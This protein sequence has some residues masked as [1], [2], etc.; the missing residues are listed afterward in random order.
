MYGCFAP[1]SGPVHPSARNLRTSSVHDVCR[2]RTTAALQMELRRMSAT[3]G[4]SRSLCS[5]LI[6]SQSYRASRNSETHLARS[7]S[8][9]HTPLKPGISANHTSSPI[10]RNDVDFNASRRYRSI[11][12]SGK[13]LVRCSFSPMRS[14]RSSKKFRPAST[15][16]SLRSCDVLV[17]S[18]R[19]ATGAMSGLYSG[20]FRALSDAETET[21]FAALTMYTGL[22]S[23]SH[24]PSTRKISVA[25]GLSLSTVP[26]LSRYSFQCSPPVWNP[27]SVA[28]TSL[29]PRRTF[30][31]RS[32]AVIQST[33]DDGYRGR[34]GRGLP[35]RPASAVFGAARTRLRPFVNCSIARS[36]SSARTSGTSS[37]S[38]LRECFFSTFAATPS[39]STRYRSGAC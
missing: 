38:E 16:I 36:G 24:I 31:R 28:S 27:L 15:T 10:F 32:I 17:V 3:T 12:C 29:S 25:T 34:L 8:E 39:G 9:A 6:T 37:A 1:Y 7:A 30:F 5:I 21:T 35:L 14:G 2:G 11:N 23:P 26:S 4:R 18:T 33:T 13:C 22:P 20:G 19:S